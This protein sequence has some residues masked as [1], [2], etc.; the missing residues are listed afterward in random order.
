MAGERE[1]SPHCWVGAD[2][3]IMGMPSP[4]TGSGVRPVPVIG[5]RRSASP[6]EAGNTIAP[7][8]CAR[9]ETRTLDGRR[10]GRTPLPMLTNGSSGTGG[11]APTSDRDGAVPP[12]FDGCIDIP[13][14]STAAGPAEIAPALQRFAREA[15]PLVIPAAVSPAEAQSAGTPRPRRITAGGPPRDGRTTTTGAR[16]VVHRGLGAGRRVGPPHSGL[17]VPLR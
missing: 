4:A 2:S 1:D 16:V 5:L 10:A 3:R 12:E 14:S 15:P 7:P 6:P 8:C 17:T 11:T 9:R 13:A